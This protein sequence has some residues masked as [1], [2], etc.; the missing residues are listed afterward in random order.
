MLLQLSNSL[1]AS[2]YSLDA[3]GAYP[4]QAAVLIAFTREQDPQVLLTRRSVEL[5]RHSGEVA[6]PG[7]WLDPEDRCLMTTALRETHEELGVAPE[8]VEVLGPWR[9]RF[10]RGGIRVQPIVGLIDPDV[11]LIPNPAE[12]DDVFKVPVSYLLRDDRFRT[13]VFQESGVE[14]WIPAYHYQ[15]FEIWGFTAGVLVDL[16]NKTL[17]GGIVRDH[18]SAPVRHFVRS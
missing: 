3:K 15:G 11:P 17:G 5:K 7:G 13:D 9:S 2:A 10:A 18:P 14:R 8:S 4:R 6:F 1:Q 12:I 16:L